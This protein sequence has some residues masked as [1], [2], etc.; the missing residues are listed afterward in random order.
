MRGLH[1]G[2]AVWALR[3]C[4]AHLNMAEEGYE[5]CLLEYRA[6]VIGDVFHFR[7]REW[8]AAALAVLRADSDAARRRA[9]APY[10]RIQRSAR[11]LV[12][13]MRDVLEEVR[14]YPLRARSAAVRDVLQRMP[15]PEVLD[16]LIDATDERWELYDRIG[17][18]RR[19]VPVVLARGG[20]GAPLEDVLTLIDDFE[21]AE[22]ARG[23]VRRRAGPERVAVYRSGRGRAAQR[24]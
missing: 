23:V 12:L 3:A 6:R 16:D 9:A 4:F 8:S 11:A 1:R 15:L 7:I 13:P 5:V 2:P 14:D 19:L 22:R 20:F 10:A 18:T 21:A 24:R 17:P